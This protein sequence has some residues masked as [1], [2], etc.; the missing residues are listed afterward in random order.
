MT[1]QQLEA[2]VGT[3]ASRM[4]ACEYKNKKQD[5]RLM[6]AETNLVAF[7]RKM[8]TA[9]AKIETLES[10]TGYITDREV[11]IPR[12]MV[13]PV[14]TSN[15]YE[16]PV[17]EK[18]SYVSGL[19]TVLKDDGSGPVVINNTVLTASIVD[20]H[21]EFAIVPNCPVMLKY[22]IR[23]KLTDIPEDF[24]LSLLE[25][26]GASAAVTSDILNIY[27]QLNALDADLLDEQ[28]T[29]KALYVQAQGSTVFVSWAYQDVPELSHFILEKWNPTT[30][31]WQPYDGQQ[32][33]VTK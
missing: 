26:N 33:V 13:T 28:L 27:Q 3:L 12:T 7:D 32:G 31:T 19:V 2:I 4:D 22:T 23:V 24:L 14:I 5:I 18:G 29:P 16:L 10:V 30:N 8:N 6:G 9:T 20:S 15:T 11:L 25:S 21:V 17:L 1:Q